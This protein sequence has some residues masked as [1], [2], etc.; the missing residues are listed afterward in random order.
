MILKSKQNVREMKKKILF[1]I[2]SVFI[3]TGVLTSCSK[4]PQAEIDSANLAITAAQSAGAELYLS[5]EYAALKDSMNSVM[6]SIET[7]KSKFIKNFNDAKEG[8][9]GVSAMAQTLTEKTAATI[10]ELKKEIQAGIDEIVNLNESN[11]LLVLE[12]PKGKEGTAA[13]EAIK[14]EIQL[15]DTSVLECK[16]LLEASSLM[17]AK[18]KVMATKEK[19]MALNSEL[20]EVIAKYKSNVKARR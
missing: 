7:E 6:T 16:D 13:L 14:A 18:T 19:A 1:G 12:A 20:T 17:E 8:L 5:A 3:V 10:E 15:V 4:V 11:S 9:L 2:I